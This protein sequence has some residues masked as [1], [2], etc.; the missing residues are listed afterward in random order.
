[1]CFPPYQAEVVSGYQTYSSCDNDPR[2]L[3]QRSEKRL[4]N[5]LR[6]LSVAF[7]ANKVKSY[8]VILTG[9]VD[10]VEDYLSDAAWKRFRKYC[11]EK[12]CKVKRTLQNLPHYK[13]SRYDY[14]ITIIP[15]FQRMTEKEKLAM[16]HVKIL[17]IASGIDNNTLLQPEGKGR[18]KKR[19]KRKRKIVVYNHY[20]VEKVMANLDLV[21]HIALYL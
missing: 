16:V 14:R 13:K 5:A 2:T 12:G 21:K 8:P 4:K 6:K 11:A 20:D 19:Q 15:F 9:I 18:Q 1:M 17:R 10:P 3:T 7:E